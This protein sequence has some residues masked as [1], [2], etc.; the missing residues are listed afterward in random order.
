MARLPNGC[1]RMLCALLQFGSLVSAVN[2]P[3][4]PT[5]RT[6]RS[7]PRTALSKRFSSLSSSTRSWPE[8]MTIG[9][10]IMSSQ[11]IGPSS[12]A[13][14]ARFCTG[15]LESS[16]S[17][18]PTTGLVG[19]CGI[20]SRLLVDAIVKCLLP[21]RHQLVIARSEATKQ[22]SL[23]A[24]DAWIASR[25]ARN[26][27]EPIPHPN[28]FLRHSISLALTSSGFSCCVQWPLPRTRYFSR[29][30]RASPCRRPP[31]AAAPRRS[32]P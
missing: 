1:S 21:A 6:R 18:L 20:G 27:G 17:M 7:E 12:L 13:S 11:K 31:T 10:P 5:A 4:P 25:S 32:R 22:S 29:S 3:S 19:G 8:T 2:R 26:D 16:D 23:A 9:E 15:A 30:A 14:R 28:R 24:P